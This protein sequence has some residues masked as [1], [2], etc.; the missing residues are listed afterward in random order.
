MMVPYKSYLLKRNVL[1]LKEIE[2]RFHNF[3]IINLLKLALSFTN[4]IFTI[5]RYLFK[6]NSF[7][8]DFNIIMARDLSCMYNTLN[9]KLD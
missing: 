3:A 2:P 8:V 7:L 6:T 4:I 5:G 9:L 1:H